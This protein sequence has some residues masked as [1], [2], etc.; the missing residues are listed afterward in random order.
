MPRKPHDAVEDAAP[1]RKS[2]GP[3]F[4]DAHPKPFE[5][6]LGRI[7]SQRECGHQVL[8]ATL[9][10]SPS[11]ISRMKDPSDPTHLRASEVASACQGVDSVAAVNEL[12]DGV[13]IQ[14]SEWRMARVAESIA[15][16]DVQVASMELVAQ[17]GEYMRALVR[18]LDGGLTRR[19]RA[20]LADELKGWRC[21]MSDLAVAIREARE[22]AGKGA[23]NELAR[24]KRDMQTAIVAAISKGEGSLTFGRPR[25]IE[26]WRL[27][28]EAWMKAAGV[29]AELNHDQRDGD[30][31]HVTGLLG[32]DR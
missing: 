28:F 14:G 22:K 2:S 15:S 31:Y 10:R 1:S 9:G 25:L 26:A 7:A 8:A 20:E 13:R 17:A 24:A 5:A 16:E 30:Y 11:S 21:E 3:G 27:D 32:A 6:S 4:T 18:R 12:F 23:D 29:K 19:E